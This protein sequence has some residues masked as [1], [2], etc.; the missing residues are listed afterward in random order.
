MVELGDGID[1]ETNRRV[2]NLVQAIEAQNVPGVEDLV[3]TYRAVLV[4]YDPLQTSLPDLQDRL[5]ILERG[6]GHQPLEAPRI[7]H[8]PTLYDE[9]S[10]PDLAFVAEHAGLAVADVVRLHSGID[11]LVYMMGFSPGFPYLGGLPERLATP[12]LDTPRAEIPAGSVGIAESQTG[13]YPMASPGGWRLIGRTPLRLFD[14]RRDPPSLIRAGDYIRFQPLSSEEEYISI[15]QEV[16]RDSY[17]VTI[18]TK[19]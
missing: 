14:A 13:V 18:S 5:S 3:P 4:Q 17:Q 1:P 15:H 16:D 7:V 12:R 11:Y 19:R 2:H 6:L 8:V 9:E 10:G